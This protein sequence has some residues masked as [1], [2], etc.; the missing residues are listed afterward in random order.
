MTHGVQ[1]FGASSGQNSTYGLTDLGELA[2]RLGSPVSFDRRGDV[3]MM[4]TFEDGLD[5]WVTDGLWSW[6]GR[7]PVAG[8]A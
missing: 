4:E 7:R 6:L 1:D 2:V 3:V 8:A 5:A